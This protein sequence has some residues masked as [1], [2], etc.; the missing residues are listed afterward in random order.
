[1]LLEKNLTPWR[2]YPD[3][4][5]CFSSGITSG[6]AFS[7]AP[8]VDARADAHCAVT[9]V[10]DIDVVQQPFQLEKIAS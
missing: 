2:T 5:S 1:M 3:E 7:E 10:L 9:I 6:C 4:P 8:A